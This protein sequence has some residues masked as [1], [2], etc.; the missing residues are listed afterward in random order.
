MAMSA[1]GLPG[2]GAR[3]AVDVRSK[4]CEDCGVKQPSFGLLSER[5][6]P[7]CSGC[8]KG[9]AGVVDA[10]SKMCEGCGVKQPS[11]GLPPE[12]TKRWCSGCAKGHTGAVNVRS[13][14]RRTD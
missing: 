14:K 10:R 8:A 11:F 6:K 5:T 12:L 7:W 9:H 3:R 2:I 1:A 4:M 13:K